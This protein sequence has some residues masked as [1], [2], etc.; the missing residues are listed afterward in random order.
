MLATLA[1][2][3]ATLLI[4][5][6]WVWS[7]S[8]GRRTV[9][10]Q[11][12]LDRRRAEL[13]E[14]DENGRR[15]NTQAEWVALSQLKTAA[16]IG[17]ANVFTRQRL[18]TQQEPGRMLIPPYWPEWRRQ[19]GF[20]YDQRYTQ[21]LTQT[22]AE[23]HDKQW[24]LPHE[25][26]EAYYHGGDGAQQSAR[27]VA[28][29]FADATEWEFVSG[30][31]ADAF[32]SF[33]ESLYL[34]GLIKE[35]QTIVDYLVAVNMEA[36]AYAVVNRN[37]P[38]LGDATEAMSDDERANARKA[39]KDLLAGDREF[40]NYARVLEVDLLIQR[41][42]SAFFL[43]TTSP[44]ITASADTLLNRTLVNQ[45]KAIDLVR[46][47]L[48]AEKLTELKSPAK[49]SEDE[50]ATGPIEVIQN[51][52]SDVVY[53]VDPSHLQMCQLAAMR[54]RMT[55]LSIATA[56]YRRDHNGRWP[57][58]LD[59]LSPD[60]LPSVPA[61]PFTADTQPLR[62]IHLRWPGGEPRPVLASVGRDGSPDFID[63][64]ESNAEPAVWPRDD[65]RVPIYD[66]STSQLDELHEHARRDD[67]L[68]DLS[69][70]PQSVRDAYSRDHA[71][72]DSSDTLE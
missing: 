11:L 56:I 69:A 63:L 60:L 4:W 29:M 26:V 2:V 52:I 41:E 22:V 18:T 72:A 13:A 37:M 30:D 44:T 57:T 66:P 31:T 45:Q 46:E 36:M 20:L 71:K 5:G 7:A 1:M 16:D 33:V 27:R 38:P 67:L 58:T 39:I 35:R 6:G 3:L 70:P 21:V 40:E 23:L 34:A 24:K 55:A 17:I 43:A 9:F 65:A 64:L 25:P 62:L 12:D 8:A 68:L 47:K 14:A 19:M 54:R 10:E 32:A 59:D 53:V 48:P 49:G 28:S 51:E 42:S 50:G 15:G 61:D